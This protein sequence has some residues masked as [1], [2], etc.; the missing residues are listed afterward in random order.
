MMARCR[1]PVSFFI[2]AKLPSSCARLALF[3]A[4]LHAVCV[5]AAASSL[6]SNW[7]GDPSIGQARLISSVT[8]K[9]DLNHLPLGLEFR[10]APK[11]KI[12][13]RTPGEAG[14]PPTVDL[15]ADG[16]PVASH[17]KWPVPKRFNAFGFDNYGYDN[18]VILPL[19]VSVFATD[20]PLQLSGHIDALVCAD[21]CVPIGGIVKMIIPGG[22]ASPSADARAIAQAAALVPRQV[23]IASLV[24]DNVWQAE[25]ALY[26]R[27]AA[28]VPIDDIFI[29]GI[30]GVAFK[31]PR[32]D[33]ADAIITIEAMSVP[34]FAG[35]DITATIVAGNAFI[36]KRFTVDAVAPELSVSKSGWTIF[37]LA[38]LG[39][40]ILNLMPCVFPVL[41]IKIGSVLDAVGQQK[42]LIRARFLSAAAG[43]VTS[44]VILAA[45]LTAMRQAGAQIGWGIQFQSPIFLSVMIL[46]LGVFVL[47]MLDRLIIP[48]PSFA[49]RWAAATSSTAAS[50]RRMLAGDFLT[51]MLTTI[52]AT[53]CS[54]P[55][56][57]V[58]VGFALTG[59]TAALFGIFIALGIGLAAPWILIMLAPGS[60][61]ALPRPGPWMNWLK[62]GLALLLVCTALWLTSILSVI[63]GLIMTGAV[64]VG[65]IMIVYGLAGQCRVWARPLLFVGSAIMVWLLFYPP[66]I[67][68]ASDGATVTRKTAHDMDTLWQAWQPGMIGPLVD[69]G[70]TVFV[71]VT[72]A[73]CITCQAN[74]SLVIEQAPVAPFIRHLVESGKLA[75]LRADWTRPSDDIAAFLASYQRYGI[76]F[77]IVYG[78][79]A[80]N[81]IQLGELLTD[82]FVLDTINKAMTGR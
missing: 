23:G 39:G 62:R 17:I 35:R 36:E 63:A 69:A 52:L 59:S 11:W 54:A 48:V 1:N 8:A 76:P 82:E 30:E 79:N 7:I 56:V 24:P 22:P 33:G 28:P 67:F 68:S 51:G 64:L 47:A 25:D 20:G 21:I 37:A 77:N 58:A 3:F 74:K 61:S 29:E 40:L 60:I 46:L 55:F 78:P 26:L 34:D 57:G 16:D 9:G 41:A 42:S 65:I 66:T 32:L 50:P 5:P 13:W 19:D 27:F 14:M 45:V 80:T 70:Q 44:F 4:F 75:L 43:I 71:D 6:H 38:L 15:L 31:R 53:P 49:Q 73:W 18:T 10:L 12:Y 72:A 2:A 81:G